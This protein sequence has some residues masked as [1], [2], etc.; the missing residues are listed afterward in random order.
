MYLYS[1]RYISQKKVWVFLA[2]SHLDFNILESPCLKAGRQLAVFWHRL[3]PTI[4]QRD[5]R[6]S[7]LSAWLILS[8]VKSYVIKSYTLLAWETREH[9]H[10]HLGHLLWHLWHAWTVIGDLKSLLTHIY[11]RQMVISLEWYC[12][13]QRGKYFSYIFLEKKR[14]AT[15]I[16]INEVDNRTSSD[17]SQPTF[18][19]WVPLNLQRNL[20]S[21]YNQ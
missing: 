1:N 16:W 19:D 17:V 10:I 7:S 8:T 11:M 3:K 14:R 18:H 20:A 15:L 4:E 6:A 5:R 13:E 2:F 9:L 21:T 12:S